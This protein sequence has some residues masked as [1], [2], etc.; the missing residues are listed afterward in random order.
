MQH[1]IQRRTRMKVVTALWA[2][3]AMV[4]VLASPVSCSKPAT[5]TGVAPQTGT[6]KLDAIT[7]TVSIASGV[8][9]PSWRI[10]DQKVIS[11]I[12]SL[13]RAG[14]PTDPPNDSGGLG[15]AGFLL[16]ANPS[17]TEFPELVRVF[18]GVVELVDDQ[19]IEYRIAPARLEQLL[20]DEAKAR[21][22][23]AFIFNTEADSPG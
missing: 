2:V 20:I 9:N 11:E 12:Q 23:E 1:R 6:D 19:A 3:G 4:L 10:V 18:E 5:T 7:V 14:T 17:D 15:F 22:V 8:P 16:Q 21:G 13:I